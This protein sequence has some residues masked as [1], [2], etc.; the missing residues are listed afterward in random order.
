MLMHGDSPNT[1]RFWMNGIISFEDAMIS[2]YDGAPDIV[3][4][5][6]YHE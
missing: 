2:H 5:Y 1:G 4:I 3:S 6:D